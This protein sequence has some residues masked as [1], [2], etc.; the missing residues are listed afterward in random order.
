MLPSTNEHAA[1]EGLECFQ[2][3]ALRE[4]PT[5]QHR[6]YRREENSEYKHGDPREFAPRLS[7]YVSGL[8]E[9]DVELASRTPVRFL[10]AG[11]FGLSSPHFPN[12]RDRA[13]SVPDN[14]ICDT[15]QQ[16]PP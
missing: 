8:I 5:G 3:F 6:F 14:R 2:L 12:D 13:M 10:K 11:A 4:K 16:S 7:A 1:R 15:A 9:K